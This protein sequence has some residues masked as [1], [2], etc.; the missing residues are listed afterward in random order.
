MANGEWLIVGAFETG[1]DII[2]GQLLGDIDTVMAT[3]GANGYGS[4]NVALEPT[5]GAFDRLKA[6]LTAN[7][8]LDVDV[9]RQVDFYRRSAGESTAWFTAVAYFLG[10][11]MGIGALFGTV[12]LMHT[13]VSKRAKEIATLRALGYGAA[14]VALSVMAEVMLLALAGALIGA[15]IA[16]LLFNGNANDLFGRIVFDLA[17]T[18]G[19]LAIGLTWAILIALLGSTIP[20]IRAARL[21]VATALRSA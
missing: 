11:I 14:P 15:A 19:L 18:P 13:A 5:D 20:A 8:A 16:W 6:A 4:V 21:P 9:E 7:P 12:N 3:R 10:A 1:G 2:D 17:V